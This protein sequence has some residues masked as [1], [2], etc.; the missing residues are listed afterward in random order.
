MCIIDSSCDA[1]DISSLSGR[2]PSLVSYNQRNPL[3][4]QPVMQFAQLLLQPV[5]LLLIFRIL[6]KPVSYTHLDVYKRQGWTI[7]RLRTV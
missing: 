4:V 5:Q 7:R 3:S 2:I 6:Q 1:L